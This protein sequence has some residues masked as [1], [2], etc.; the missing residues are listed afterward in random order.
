[1][2]AANDSAAGVRLR[3][4]WREVLRKGR[5]EGRQSRGCDLRCYWRG[6][7]YEEHQGEEDVLQRAHGFARMMQCLEPIV[8]AE[9]RLAGSARGF[10]VRDLPDG[11]S[12]AEYERAVEKDRCKG[13]RNFRAGFDHTLAHYPMLLE[14]GVPGLIAKAEAARSAQREPARRR[15]LDAVIIALRG[16]AE[17][18][19]RHSRAAAAA[20]NAETAASLE[21]LTAGP[22]QSLEDAVQLVWLTHLAFLA[23]GRRHMAPGRV[24]QYLRPYYERDLRAG[25]TSE[26]DALDLL[27]H[28]WAKLDEVGHVQNICIGG[29]RP[30]GTDGTNELSYLCLKAT[31]LVH[32]P[33]TNLSARLHDGTPAGFFEA[34]AE[35]V[36]TGIGFPAIFNDHVLVPGLAALGIPEEAARDHCFVGCIETMLAG[37]Q[38]AWSDSRFNIALCLS[39]ALEALRAEQSPSYARLLELFEQDLAQSVQRHAQ[40][41]NASIEAFPVARFGD[42]FLSALTLECIERGLDVNDGGALF[43]RFHGIAGMGLGTAADALAAVKKLVFEEQAVSFGDLMKALDA[44]FAGHELVRQMLVNKAPKYGNADP[45]VDRIAAWIVEKFTAA[46]LE[47]RLPCGGRHVGLM[48]ANV[49][50]IPAGK[51]VCAT[52]DGRKAFTPLSDAASPYFGRDRNGPTAFIASVSAPDYRR[53]VGGSVINMRFDPRHFQGREGTQRLAAFF[54]VFVKNRIQELQFNFTSDED[55]AAAQK[56]PESYRSLLVR[57]SGFSAYFVLLSAE[58]QADV[59]RR[60]AHG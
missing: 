3:G 10:V 9:D 53:A 60:R 7:A 25:R 36:K 33:H 31:D 19:R 38:P 34:C 48:A 21:R 22:A 30:D 50:N 26:E 17:F 35:L 45:Y 43:P 5:A 49:S 39:R 15:F 51:E 6:L 59:M 24:D 55:L 1:M 20:G 12:R 37:C 13:Q 32:S 28:L 11:I 41:V 44:D 27:C 40:Q 56:D 54:K 57:V 52:P 14:L 18:I 29:L 58:V 23:E 4:D 47:Q 16:F 2:S 42:P 46:C 8:S